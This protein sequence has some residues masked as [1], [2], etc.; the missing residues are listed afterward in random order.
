MFQFNFESGTTPST[1]NVIGLPMYSTIGTLTT[2]TGVCSGAVSVT[3]S[4]WNTGDGYRFSVN[5]TGFTSLRFSY[6]ERASNV[7]IGSFIVRASTDLFNWTTIRSLYTPTTSCVGSGSLALPNGFDAQA[8][9]YIEIYKSA[10]AASAANT[11][12]IDDVTLTG[13]PSIPT[14]SSLSPSS[15]AAGAGAFSLTVNGTDFIEGLSAVTWNGANRTTTFISTT[16]LTASIS[17]T[18]IASAGIV[19][20]GVTT[21]GAAPSNTQTF[22]V[23]NANAPTT[24]AI[25][26]INAG[27]HVVEGIPFSVTVQAQDG[28]GT[29]ANVIANTSFSL[30]KVLGSGSLRGTLTGTIVAGS[31]TVTVSNLTYTAAESGVAI[32]AARTDGDNLTAGTS[33]GFAV[34]P[35]EPTTQPTALVRTAAS[36]TGMTL[37]WAAASGP[38]AGYILLRTTVT[39][40]GYPDTAPVDGF[41]YA[42]GDTLGNATVEYIGNGFSAVTASALIAA[43]PYSYA[44]YSYNGSGSSSNYHISLPLQGQF[45]TLAAEPAVAASNVSFSDPSTTG[46]TINF[47]SGTGTGRLVIVREA[48]AVDFVPADGTA[49]G[50]NTAFTSGT[51]L[52]PS[53]DN[54]VVYAG[55]GASISITGLSAGTNYYVAVYEYSGSST[56]INYHTTAAIG[57][58]STLVVAPATAASA[59]TLVSRTN[60][61][62]SLSWTAG[63]GSGRIVVVRRSNVSTVTPSAGTPYAVTTPGSFTGPGNSNTGVNNVVVYDG[64]STSLT[65]TNLSSETAYSFSV[66]EYNGSGS[67]IAYA[68]GASLNSEF[69]LADEPAV[70]ASS[71]TA[72]AANSSAIHLAFDAASAL[73]ADGYLLLKKSTAFTNADYPTDGQAYSIGAVVGGATINSVITNS[74]TTSA[75]GTSVIANTTYHY[76]LVPFNWDG[77]TSTTRNYYTGGTVPTAFATTPS[78]SSTPAA[79]AGSES[80][81]ISSLITAPAPLSAF[82]GV[83]VWQFTINDGGASLNDADLLPTKISDFTLTANLSSS[84][85]SWATSIKTAAL[86]EGANLIASGTVGGSNIIFSGLSLVIPDGMAKTY[87][88]RLSLNNTLGTT[89]DGK[90]FVFNLTPSN[91]TTLSDGT[92]SDFTPTGSVNSSTTA[93]VIDVVATQYAFG[94][95]PTDVQTYVSVSP[96]VTVKATDVNGNIDLGY[97]GTVSI[98]ASGATLI[99]SPVGIAAVAGI[100][101]FSSLQFSSVGVA[102]LTASGNITGVSSNAITITLGMGSYTYRTLRDGNWTSITPGSEVWERSLDGLNFTTVTQPEDLPTNNSGAIVISHVIV[103][104]AARTLDQTTIA[105]G[106]TLLQTSGALTI[107][108]GIGHDLTIANGGTLAMSLAAPTIHS[109]ATIRVATGGLLTTSSITNFVAY[110]TPGNYIFENASVLEYSGTSTPNI[111]AIFFPDA[112]ASTIPVLRFSGFIDGGIGSGGAFVVN[113]VLEVTGSVTLTTTGTR[114]F[115]NG[116]RGAGSLVQSGIGN[117]FEITGATAEIGGGALTL[118]SSG[119]TIS[120]NTSASLASAK[121]VTGGT[122]IVN[123]I[124]DLHTHALSGS[125]NLTVNST[126]TVKLGSVSVSGAL[127][128][129]FTS[130]GPLTLAVGSTVEFNGSA[131]QFAASG[132]FSNLTINNSHGVTAT[133]A[134]TVNGSMTL[135]SGT[136]DNSIN[137]I[138]LGSGAHIVRSNGA[139]SAAPAFPAVINISYTG[140]GDITTGFE[141]PAAS[142]STLTI[143]RTGGKVILTDSVKVINA[144]ALTSGALQLNGNNLTLAAGAGLI[145]GSKQSHVVTNGAGA[146]IRLGLNGTALFPVGT[147]DSSYS[148]VTINNTAT[149]TDWMVSVAVGIAPAMVTSNRA[150]NRT[151][152]ITPVNTSPGATNLTFQYDE[153]DASIRGSGWA[154]GYSSSGGNIIGISHY[155]GIADN[156]WELETTVTP[157]S[158]GGTVYNV[159]RIA[160]TSFSPFALQNLGFVLPVTVMNFSGKRED[161]VN[162]LLWTTA[163]EVHNKGF[164]VE[165][166]LDGNNYT[167]IAFVQSK[168]TGGTSSWPLSYTFND[169]TI[170][171][172]RVLY[173]LVQ[174]DFDGRTQIS[175]VVAIH[176]H[177]ISVLS[178]TRTYPNPV[179]NRLNLMLQNAREGAVHFFVTNMGG[180]IVKRLTRVLIAGETTVEIDVTELPSGSYFLKAVAEDGATAAA[181]FIK[182]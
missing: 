67:T 170:I 61:S 158:L 13:T 172:G 52:G 71:F 101:T 9:V 4:A 167:A 100:A 177:S 176:N 140:S 53:L 87:T 124:L 114:I 178:L 24:L 1:D 168:A 174:E 49:Y 51:G 55:T 38:V 173:R 10:D 150:L 119:L 152:M 108:N 19:P 46:F 89:D 157:T 141:L 80:V 35:A 98:T 94:Q 160:Q 63:N 138:L 107:S 111:T 48:A 20:V 41:S 96:A 175:P 54:K 43:S 29:P 7:A 137:N 56:S 126:G 117:A 145:G 83:Q 6:T 128:D 147:S 104:S 154:L 3:H 159:T 153:S 118:T 65:I 135:L 142:I 131:P 17:A 106:G 179:R 45:Y 64:S 109:G 113:G 116:I 18:D 97:T 82:T 37:S 182:Q 161:G 181:T 121:V 5:T 66:Y 39:G 120:T 25:T 103:T 125:A 166:S 76:L 149:I 86:F 57:N 77:T 32:T 95:Q 165:R 14:I 36:P 27:N 169:N 60:N 171:N 8:T 44:I 22:S 30:S 58:R 156:R 164:A 33:G 151:W 31:T 74:N 143:N 11:Y 15:I 123:G 68:T 12:R 105:S 136:F 40:T 122:I 47:T 112:D 144:L 16:Q 62:I 93:N 50:A 75:S 115:R 146:L 99:G 88:L 139:L 132:T 23:I 102:N 91:I 72:M 134:V 73:S 155:D 28:S 78:A 2:N 130:S 79:V 148:P 127:N 85:A 26:A 70:H 42:V 21:A 129:N 81:T 92:S 133:G 180:E 163:S 59:L 162:K 84:V 90:K 69:T 34:L 110:G